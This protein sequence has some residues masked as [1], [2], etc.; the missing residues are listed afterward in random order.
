M[1][2]IHRLSLWGLILSL[3]RN[4]TGVQGASPQRRIV[5]KVMGS[6]EKRVIML[7]QGIGELLLNE[8]MSFSI[9]EGMAWL[10]RAPY[11]TIQIHL[12]QMPLICR[13]YED[14]S[15]KI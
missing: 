9:P 8:L 11:L 2:V 7:D 12:F 1:G 13:R 6:R 4:K 14:F 15:L 3:S 10:K 5:G